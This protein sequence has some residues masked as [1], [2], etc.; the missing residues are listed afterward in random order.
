MLRTIEMKIKKSHIVGFTTSYKTK[1][2]FKL[3][4]KSFIIFSL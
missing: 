2:S 4:F 3:S 1:T